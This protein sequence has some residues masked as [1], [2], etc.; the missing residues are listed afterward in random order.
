MKLRAGQLDVH[1]DMRR[2]PAG[3]VPLER[4]LSK[5]GV[6][7]RSK[8]RASILEGKIAVDGVT[9]RDPAFPV[10]PERVRI[11]VE[12]EET[13]PKVWRC[14]LLHKPRSFITSSADEK[15]RPTVFDLVKEDAAGLHS[16]GRLDWATSGLLLLT[17]D[18]KLSSW[19]TDPHHAIPRTYLV[20][21]KPA[22][23]EGALK[24]LTDGVRV[25]E[26]LLQASEAVLRKTCRKESHLVVTL[27]QGKNREIRRMLASL[28][29]E[30]TRLKRVGFG[31][32]TLGDL[33]PGK[34]RSVSKDELRALFPGVPFATT[35]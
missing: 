31:G 33:Q 35:L 28:G 14:L 17:N 15:G 18:S 32:L 23:E 3:M 19:L 16:V 30:V 26:E 11:E 20:S 4:A 22:L 25:D 9:R 13:A 21:I 34:Y 7:S 8:A 29:K 27:Q 1:E 5:L 10:V 24:K 2:F 12:H 6:L